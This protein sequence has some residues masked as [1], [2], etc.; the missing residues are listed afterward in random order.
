MTGTAA[1]QAKLINTVSKQV[2]GETR[3]RG[4]RIEAKTQTRLLASTQECKKNSHWRL[5]DKKNLH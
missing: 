1:A 3:G 4:L 5:S 2:A